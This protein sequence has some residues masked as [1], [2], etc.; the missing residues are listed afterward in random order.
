MGMPEY[1]PGEH[2]Q[3]AQIIATGTTNVM[4]RECLKLIFYKISN[5][6]V[7]K[8][9]ADDFENLHT[10]ISKTGLLGAIDSLRRAQ[11]QDLTIRAFMDNLFRDL[12]LFMCYNKRALNMESPKTLVKWLLSLGQDPNIKLFTPF[13]ISTALEHATLSRQVDIIKPLLR[14]GAVVG[15]NCGS[16]NYRSIISIVLPSRICDNEGAH[17][18]RLFLDHYK[19]LSAEEILHAAILL[20]DERLFQQALDIGANISL[21]IETLTVDKFSPIKSNVVKEET[22]LSTAAAVSIHA[23]S[24]VFDLLQNRNQ[25]IKASSFITPDVFVS[26][27][28]A[29]SADIIS[30]LHEINPVGFSSNARGLTP[31]EVAIKNGHEEA[32]QLLFKLYGQSSATL[33]LIPIFTDQLEILQYLLENGLD[34]NLTTKEVDIST[35]WFLLPDYLSNRF[36][37][38]IYK[39]KSPTVLELLLSDSRVRETRKHAIELLVSSGAFVRGEAILESSIATHNDILFAALDALGDPNIQHLCVNSALPSALRSK[40]IKWLR[41]LLERGAELQTLTS[42]VIEA[43]VP[44][45]VCN[46]QGKRGRC[47]PSFRALLLE[48]WANI[49]DT[50][51]D[52]VLDIDAAIIA[53]HDARLKNAFSEFP[54]YYSPS[55]LCSAVLVE[56]HW[57]IDFLLKNRSLQAPHDTLEGTAVGLA[58][59]LGNLPLVRKLVTQLQKPETAIL[60]FLASRS[61]FA[62]TR[63]NGLDI[64][65]SHT[66]WHRHPSEHVDFYGSTRRRLFEGSPLALA[67]SYRETAGVLELLSHGYQPDD[68]TWARALSTQDGLKTL[69]DYNLRVRSLELPLSTFSPL[70]MYAIKHGMGEAV[71]WLIELGADIN[72]NDVLQDTSRS[73]VQLAIEFGHLT[74]TETLL[75]SGSNVNAAPSF[76]AGVTALQS[77]AIGGHIGLVKQL[78]DAGARVNARGSRWFGRTALEG[79][80]ERGRLDMVELLLHHRAL[81]T[82]PGRFQF[83]RA[84]HMAVRNGHYATAA[85]LRQS[86]EWTDE[87]IHTYDSL[88]ADCK[89]SFSEPRTISH[90]CDASDHTDAP[91]RYCCDEIHMPEDD[92]YRCYTED[93]ESRYELKTQEEEQWISE[94]LKM[95]AD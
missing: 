71:V 61:S 65:S 74:V 55:S 75:R 42:Q 40:N 94:L 14:A 50:S 67:A 34:V 20:E 77:A 49:F 70:L 53:Q 1:F 93:E 26:A 44:E 19:V 89:C 38:C 45:Y 36:S 91:G 69:M 21:P 17:I 47:D 31:L 13:S 79:A 5:N 58:A 32:Y 39:Q 68:I 54:T 90:I 87:D 43:L 88:C 29:G 22:A 23:A 60:P 48:H 27:A 81:T 18:L 52:S 46:I 78:L 7:S 62:F 33:L 59:M 57:T 73:P 3:T 25:V 2:L 64:T 41:L 86:R 63:E 83:I 8:W 35:C 84:I 30:F 37:Y 76:V 4:I 66:F 82:G 6:M 12:I 16:P 28:C 72:E 85:L 11:Q 10:I 51:K 92:C 15:R 56:N 95:I 24:L 9:N 80:A